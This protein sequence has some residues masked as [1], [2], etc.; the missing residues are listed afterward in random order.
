[1]NILRSAILII[2]PANKNENNEDWVFLFFEYLS[3][4]NGIRLIYTDRIILD[5][6]EGVAKNGIG[7]KD[8]KIMKHGTIAIFQII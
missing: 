4:N 2:L 7:G 1:M 3:Q 6:K 5:K 8:Q